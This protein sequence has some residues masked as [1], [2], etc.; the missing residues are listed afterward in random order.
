LPRLKLVLV[1]A[2]NEKPIDYDGLF[3]FLV[4]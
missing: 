4:L 2:G 3:Y 1:K